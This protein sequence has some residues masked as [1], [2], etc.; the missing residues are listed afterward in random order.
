MNSP[1][2]IVFVFYLL[3]S[4]LLSQSING[5]VREESTGE[6]ISYANVFLSN[7]ALGA[8]TSRDGYFVITDVPKGEYEFNVTMIGYSVYKEKIS[9]T[10]NYGM[11]IVD[12]LFDTDELDPIDIVETLAT[13]YDWDFDRITEDQ[14]AMAIEGSWRTYGVTLSWTTFDETLRIICSFDLSPP[15]EKL[16]KLLETLNLANNKVWNGSFVFAK[17]QNL[18][19]LKTLIK[20]KLDLFLTLIKLNQKYKKFLMN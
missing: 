14:I 6:P 10:G 13:H 20:I 12:R 2:R 7:T 9:Y 1:Y 15:K 17:K 18:M 8:A 4:T 5:F 16:N 19:V 3:V 11:Y